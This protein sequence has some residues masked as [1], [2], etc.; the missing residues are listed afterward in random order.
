MS[1]RSRFREPSSSAKRHEYI[2]STSIVDS[3]EEFWNE[4]EEELLRDESL[5]I[6]KEGLAKLGAKVSHIKGQF[7]RVSEQLE[8]LNGNRNALV[9][10]H[11]PRLIVKW[12]TLTHEFD[13]AVAASRDMCTK[14]I[15]V[16]QG[17]IKA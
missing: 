1:P 12:N 16:I 4:I 11:C 13:D 17:I 5:K 6:T 9:N 14:A 15:G 10:E 2:P 7:R 8:D 3:E